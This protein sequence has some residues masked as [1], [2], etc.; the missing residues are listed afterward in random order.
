MMA[1]LKPILH[2][3]TQAV[4]FFIVALQHM[5]LKLR[6]IY[7]RLGKYNV[8]IIVNCDNTVHISHISFGSTGAAIYAPSKNT[9]AINPWSR[10][11]GPIRHGVQ[12]GWMLKRS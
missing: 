1:L 12:V 7:L 3:L 6:I 8:A 5:N 11:F 9:G 10:M 2:R 4:S